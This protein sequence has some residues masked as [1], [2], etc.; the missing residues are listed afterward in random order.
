MWEILRAAVRSLR[1]ERMWRDTGDESDD[2]ICVY[3]WRPFF[4]SKGIELF[5]RRGS[6]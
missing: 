1:V 5:A 6:L 4:L 3:V 2:V